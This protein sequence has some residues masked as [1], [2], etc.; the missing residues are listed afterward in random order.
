[1]NG[2]YLKLLSFFFML[3]AYDVYGL[4]MNNPGQSSQPHTQTQT[5]PQ[6]Q[7]F[8]ATHDN[9]NHHGTKQ[10]SLATNALALHSFHEQKSNKRIILDPKKYQH[11]NEMEK[12]LENF[13]HHR[14]NGDEIL[15]AQHTGAFKLTKSQSGNHDYYEAIQ[16]AQ[17]SSP[18]THQ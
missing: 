7:I 8:A 1:M 4:P 10:L 2:L 6:P 13:N 18:E 17:S 12:A 15:K 14:K 16:A 11:K 5:H 9:L 3:Y